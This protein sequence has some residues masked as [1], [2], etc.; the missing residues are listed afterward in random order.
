MLTHDEMKTEALKRVTA[1]NPG[2]TPTSSRVFENIMDGAVVGVFFKTKEGKENFEL[3]VLWSRR[4]PGLQMVFRRHSGRVRGT[5][6][7]LA[8]PTYWTRWHGGVIALFLV[9]AFSILLS[10]LAFV[11]HDSTVLE[12]VKL[13]FTL[14]L[15]FFFGSQTA[16]KKTA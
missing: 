4:G 13:S 1:N 2:M 8:L 14:I 12:V 9:L 6:A 15:G 7:E 3:R 16:N 11:P 5:R 10:I